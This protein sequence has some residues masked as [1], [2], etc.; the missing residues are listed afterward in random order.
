MTPE[1]PSDAEV[2]KT[3]P[4]VLLGMVSWPFVWTYGMQ[5]LISLSPDEQEPSA[6]IFYGVILGV[7]AIVISIVLS[8]VKLSKRNVKG[9][10]GVSVNLIGL[11]LMTLF[12]WGPYGI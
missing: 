5:V 2:L 9:L 8:M 4:E 11:G 6:V 12:P 1:A 10:I 7:L 3:Y